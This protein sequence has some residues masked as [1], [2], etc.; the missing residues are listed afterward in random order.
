MF[1]RIYITMNIKNV[2]LWLDCRH[3]GVCATDQCRRQYN[4]LFH[5]K[6]RINQILPQVVH[7]LRFSGR[8][9]APHFEINV[10]GQ[11][12]SVDR[13]LEVHTSLLHYWIFGLGAANDAHNVRADT[14][15]GK[16]NDHQNISKIKIWYRSVYNKTPSDAWRYNTSVYELMTDKLQLMLINVLLYQFLNIKVLQGSAATRLRCDG[17]YNDQ[18]I[19]YHCWV[20]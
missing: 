17:N 14:A 3:G 15:R 5:S 8:L 12:C 2:L 6:S 10:W 4:A 11:G 13:N 19:A 9:A 7:I 1:W 20:W 18:F 16:D